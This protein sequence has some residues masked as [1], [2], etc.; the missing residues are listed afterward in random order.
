M[1]AGIAPLV[2]AINAVGIKTVSSCEGHHERPAYVAVASTNGWGAWLVVSGLRSGLLW[3]NLEDIQVSLE[4][5]PQPEGSP[6]P[7]RWVVWLKNFEKMLPGDKVNLARS[8]GEHLTDYVSKR[9]NPPP[10]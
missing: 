5:V 7:S 1:E 2:E 4:E 9:R 3:E 10:E 8:L 6:Y